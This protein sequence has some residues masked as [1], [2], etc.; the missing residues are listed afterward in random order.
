MV[1]V[2]I[3]LGRGICLSPELQTAGTRFRMI[4]VVV[5]TSGITDTGA[6]DAK[7]DELQ[8]FDWLAGS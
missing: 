3:G 4:A 7:E 8:S 1:F 5:R 2:L 6:E